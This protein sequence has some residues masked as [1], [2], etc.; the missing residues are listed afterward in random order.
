[1]EFLGS[2]LN[3]ITSSNDGGTNTIQSTTVADQFTTR[4][5]STY[6]G[7]ISGYPVQT[8]SY[9][10]GLKLENSMINLILINFILGIVLI[11]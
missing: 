7:M 5:Y 9:N 11:V 4:D 2:I 10:N 8:G 1:M 6:T 3:S